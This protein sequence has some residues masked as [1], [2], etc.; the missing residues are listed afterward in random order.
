MFYETDGREQRAALLRLI[1]DQLKKGSRFDPVTSLQAT[2]E[3]L[4]ND[5]LKSFIG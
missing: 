2:W 1:F 3:R 5:A 4:E